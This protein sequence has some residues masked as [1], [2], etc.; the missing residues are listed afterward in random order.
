MHA[1]VWLK[2]QSFN[3]RVRDS[4]QSDPY[5]STRS[6]FHRLGGGHFEYLQ[7]FWVH[8]DRIALLKF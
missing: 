4:L 1:S 3:T 8:K 2:A 5:M 7:L 6:R